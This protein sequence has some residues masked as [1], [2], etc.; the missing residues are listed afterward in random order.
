MT[1]YPARFNLRAIPSPRPRLPPVTTTLRITTY[2]LPRFSNRERGNKIDR[3]WDLIRGE[4]F[5]TE[6]DDIISKFT[7]IS[8][9][10]LR[11]S[12]NHIGNYQRACNRILLRPDKRNLYF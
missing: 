6:Q 8:L 10:R 9:L 2:H 3:S 12:Q 11:R 4:S 5:T 7:N 1:R